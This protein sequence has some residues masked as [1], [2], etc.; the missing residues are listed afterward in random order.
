M[1][2]HSSIFSMFEVTFSCLY[3]FFLLK[4]FWDGKKK[5]LGILNS[6]RTD[7]CLTSL[8]SRNFVSNLW[9]LSS[10]FGFCLTI[11]L[12]RLIVPTGGIVSLDPHPDHMFINSLATWYQALKYEAKSVL[13]IENLFLKMNQ[14][15]FGWVDILFMSIIIPGFVTKVITAYFSDLAI[16]MHVLTLRSPVKEFIRL[17][18]F[19]ISLELMENIQISSLSRK[20]E[21]CR[22][23]ISEQSMK[24]LKLIKKYEAL[25]R[26]SL[27]LNESLGTTLFFYL[28][29]TIIT[30]AIHFH[31]LFNS[32]Y[33]N[34]LFGYAIAIFYGMTFS[35]FFCSSEICRQ[36]N[37][38]KTWLFDKRNILKMD[39]N[40]SIFLLN[41]LESKSVGISACDVV[42]ISYSMLGTVLGLLVTFFVISLPTACNK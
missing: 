24:A 27:Q 38:F 29:E 37:L 26:L 16:L 30:Y 8:K 31:I 13:F 17:L 41:A 21:L 9:F 19:E 28:G 15:S 5:I 25:K 18:K 39:V 42:T 23:Q 33:G 7:P 36:M 6:F 2:N 20:L 1:D 32:F 22:N 10:V 35:V 14:D 3:K 34:A 11:A 40:E 4:H 12:S